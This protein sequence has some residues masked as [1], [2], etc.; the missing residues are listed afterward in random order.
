MC[1]AEVEVKKQETENM[2]KMLFV[3]V[4]AHIRISWA[5]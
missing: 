1:C 3:Y 5:L 4:G 2:Q